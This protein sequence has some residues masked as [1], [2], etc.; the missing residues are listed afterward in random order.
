MD[1]GHYGTTGEEGF[2]LIEL[3]ITVAIIGI[4]AAIATPGLIAGQ[5]RARYSTA[6]ADTRQIITQAWILTGDSNQVA[7]TACGNPMP[8]CLWD[9]SAP[10]GRYYVAKAN[11]PWASAGNSYRWNQSPAPGCGVATPDCVVYASW[12]IGANGADDNGGAWAGAAPPL[13]DD[14]GNSTLVGC[15]YGPAVPIGFPC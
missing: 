2:T 4:L 3:L 10:N 5:Q 12:T 1:M 6:A 14:L 13:V 15:S 9:G 11:D 7:D 8:A